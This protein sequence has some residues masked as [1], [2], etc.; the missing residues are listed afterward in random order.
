VTSLDDE[1]RLVPVAWQQVRRLVARARHRR[2]VTL[3][4]TLVLAG[5]FFAVQVR[6]PRKYEAEVGLLIT[7]G[8]FAADGRP[9]PR[10][11]LRAFI[12]HAISV[13]ARLEGV[14]SKHDLRKK[15]G[16]S[17][18]ADTVDRVR[19]L[20]EVHTWHDY[21]EGYRQRMDPPRSVR[22][23][24]G[25]SAPDPSLALAV[26]RD[27]GELVAETQTAHESEVAAAHV[28]GLRLLAETAAARAAD[29]YQQLGRAREEAW[30]HPSGAEDLRLRQLGHAA[31]VAED[32]SKSAAVN[33][34]DAQIQAL[35]VRRIGGLVQV[36]DPG[37][38]LSDT[39]S[40][41]ERLVRW[42]VLSLFAAIFLAVIL[43]GAADP[44]ILDEQ[45]LRRAGLRPLGSLPVSSGR[46]SGA[47]V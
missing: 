3:S 5:M 9:R 39:V 35:A 26:A 36:V 12:N 16:G 20:I 4:L 28:D 43:V 31:K 46:S 42:A 22:V 2:F 37:L 41:A 40:R 17:S 8:A 29:Q 18:Q 44:T 24:I 6:R 23:T 32:A 38:S 25:F 1:Q 11:E 7:E 19:K 34:V 47:G 10:G 15:L 27:L 13:A 33:L 14:I 30:G 45:D 21:F